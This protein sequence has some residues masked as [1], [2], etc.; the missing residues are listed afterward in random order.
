LFQEAAMQKQLDA[1]DQHLLMA[2]IEAERPFRTGALG[3]DRFNR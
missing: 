1:V 2:S 3:H